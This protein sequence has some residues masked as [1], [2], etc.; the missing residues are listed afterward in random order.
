MNVSQAINTELWSGLDPE[1][2]AID[3][4]SH[5][6][7]MVVVLLAQIQAVI[8]VQ[9]ELESDH[10]ELLIRMALRQANCWYFG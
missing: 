8:E 9:T 6:G 4:D 2:A 5:V 3:A 7:R 1:I 10:R